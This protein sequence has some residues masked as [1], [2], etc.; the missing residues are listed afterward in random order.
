MYKVLNIRTLLNNKSGQW[1]FLNF[2]LKIINNGMSE[3]Q[4][5]KLTDYYISIRLIIRNLMCASID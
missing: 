1:A 3:F 5:L 2:A 4:A